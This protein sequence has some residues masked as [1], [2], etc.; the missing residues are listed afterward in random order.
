MGATGPATTAGLGERRKKPGY[1]FYTW[2]L[3]VEAKLAGAVD[4]EEKFFVDVG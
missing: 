1:P 3:R 2:E 4:Y